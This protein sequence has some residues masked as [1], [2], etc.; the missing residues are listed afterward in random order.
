MSGQDSH[1]FHQNQNQETYPFPIHVSQV[2]MPGYEA[3]SGGQ[4]NTSDVKKGWSD[5]R[6]KGASEKG[7]VGVPEPGPTPPGAVRVASR[8]PGHFETFQG[9]ENKSVNILKLLMCFFSRVCSD[10]FDHISIYW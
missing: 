2:L 10:F 7:R 1:R 3:P 6:Q 5:W 4:K 9:G 8:T